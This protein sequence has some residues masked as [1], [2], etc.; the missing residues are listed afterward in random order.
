MRA[1]RL[2]LASSPATRSCRLFL[3]PALAACALVCRL[4]L[5]PCLPAAPAPCRACAV[6]HTRDVPRPHCLPHPRC[7]AP[8]LFATPAMCRSCAVCHPATF[9]ARAMRYTRAVPRS[10]CADTTLRPC[11]ATP[12]LAA[13]AVPR[14]RSLP[15]LTTHAVPHP[16]PLPPAGAA[17]AGSVCVRSLWW[18]RVRG[19]TS[20]RDSGN[21]RVR[22][23][24][25]YFCISCSFIDHFTLYFFYAVP[26]KASKR[27]CRNNP[28][29]CPLAHARTHARAHVTAAFGCSECTQNIPDPFRKKP[30]PRAKAGRPLGPGLELWYSRVWPNPHSKL[31]AISIP[32]REAYRAPIMPWKGPRPEPQ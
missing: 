9:H 20:P 3:P 29:D 26:E 10:R 4:H 22:V 14:P 21:N 8:A 24:A 2:R 16:R 32:K 18:L 30:D 31:K 7:A 13:R 11:R 6:R 17:C 28:K 1:R 12:A 15:A 27:T 25:L 19:R 5:R 23:P